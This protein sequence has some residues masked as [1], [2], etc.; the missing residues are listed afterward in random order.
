MAMG[1]SSGCVNHPGIQSTARCKQCNKP[2]CN[3]CR[4]DA[5]TGAFCS[6]V[7]REKFETFVQRAAQ[8]EQMRKPARFGKVVKGLIGKLIVIFIL[9]LALGILG[10]VME[11]PVLTP[12]VET[13]RGKLGV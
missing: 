11:V 8:L 9:L 1:T 10:S 3:A 5:P 2:V 6:E 4:V 7:C 12:L 13:V